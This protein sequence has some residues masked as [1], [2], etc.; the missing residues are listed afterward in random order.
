MNTHLEHARTR[1]ESEDFEMVNTPLHSGASR[2]PS[3][4]SEE[5]HPSVY[6]DET[7]REVVLG[8][9]LA[10]EDDR[11]QSDSTPMAN[12]LSE[13]I[14]EESVE[15][16]PD[17]VV[18]LPHDTTLMTRAEI[19]ALAIGCLIVV[20]SVITIA[21][22]TIH[23]I[24]ETNKKVADF[25][26]LDDNAPVEV[27]N[28]SVEDCQP[29]LL[30]V[31]LNETQEATP[32]AAKRPATDLIE[33]SGAAEPCKWCLALCEKLSIGYQ[34]SAK[35]VELGQAVLA[36]KWTEFVTFCELGWSRM[37]SKWINA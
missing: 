26:I 31:A 18:Y 28:L 12:E 20:G 30:I 2:N 29:T 21:V 11:D 19:L 15:I 3:I 16:F 24:H 7:E 10:I 25:V 6:G 32:P 4:V 13:L 14:R 23:P 36:R 22:L 37:M 8:K 34:A 35:A 33:V 27:P 17:N 5:E 9:G 1:T